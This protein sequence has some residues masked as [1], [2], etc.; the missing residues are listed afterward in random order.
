MAQ[1]PP[2]MVLSHWSTLVENFQTSPLSFYD[3]VEAALKRR[4]IPQ[5]ENSRVDYKEAG[6]LSAKR[7]YLHVKREKLVFVDDARVPTLIVGESGGS[8][9]MLKPSPRRR[10][11]TPSEPKPPE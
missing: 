11:S 6:L 10:Y 7:E 8:L 9:Q 3:A 2:E 5:T 4:E 1:T